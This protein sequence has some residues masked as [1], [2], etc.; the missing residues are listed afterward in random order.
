MLSARDLERW[1]RKAADEQ[2]ARLFFTREQLSGAAA[3]RYAEED[4]PGELTM[5]GKAFPLRYRFAPG[6]PDDG[7]SVEVPISLLD[8]VVPQV[9]NWSVPGMLAGV[10]EQWLR[11]LEKSKR[12]RLTPIPDAVQAILP[13]LTQPSIYRQG[14]LEVSLANAIEHEFGLKIAAEDWHP[15]RIEPQ[16]QVNVKVLGGDGE[17]LAESREFD[18]LKARFAAE[19]A[20]RMDEGLKSQEEEKGLIEF[21]DQPPV[22]S[23]VIG[24]PGAEVV[25]YPALIDEGDTVALRHLADAVAQ[26][27]ANRSGLSRLALLKLGQTARYLKK[28]IAADK[29][30]GVLYAPWVAR[31]SFVMSC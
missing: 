24:D 20:A 11:S 25:A 2:S 6:A 7:V 1:L 27:K 13:I 26:A 19:V 23:V 12:R 28:Q 3:A 15:E 31:S 5:R 29:A 16:W 4:F 10:C 22:G 18:G 14:R 30:L 8:A 21:P 9:L 17:V